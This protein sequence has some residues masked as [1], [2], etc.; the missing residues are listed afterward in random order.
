MKSTL[1]AVVGILV[2]GFVAVLLLL[3]RLSSGPIQLNQLIPRIERA[4]SDLPGGVSV[5]L[6]GVGLYLNRA[7]RQVDLKAVSVELLESS[8][9]ILASMPEVEISLSGFALLHGVIA[10]SSIELHDVDVQLVR[11]VDGSF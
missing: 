7:E 2:V 6:K 3:W 5:R 1:K 8:G 9:T 11:N 10:L 4:A